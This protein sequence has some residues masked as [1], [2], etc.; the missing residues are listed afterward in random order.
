MTNKFFSGLLVGVVA[1]SSAFA[2]T[3]NAPAPGATWVTNTGAVATGGNPLASGVPGTFFW[4]NPSYDASTAASK[5]NVGYILQGTATIGGP[6]ACAA[7]PIS[8][9]GVPGTKLN[10]LA[11]NAAGTLATDFTFSNAVQVASTFRASFTGVLGGDE[12]GWYNT[13]LPAVLHPI[14]T[15][16]APGVTDF[17]FT[18][19]ATWGVYLKNSGALFLS[20][21]EGEQFALFSQDPGNPAGPPSDLKHYWIGAEDKLGIN[22][23]WSAGGA[24]DY[25]FNDMLV[26]MQAVPE[27][28]YILLLAAGFAGLF[29]ARR[30]YSVV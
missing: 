24:G 5:C 9:T 17:T 6:N 21:S 25:D 7:T 27:P 29:Y 18:P 22:N 26:E 3:V 15:T 11:G 2:D 20:G 14:F 30:R 28:G 4:D 8:P 1:V 19:S 23:K 10:F 13:L 16:A 12:F